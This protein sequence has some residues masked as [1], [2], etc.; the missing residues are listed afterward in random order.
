MTGGSLPAMTWQ[1]LMDYA[2]QNIDLKPIPGIDN[3]FVE[4]DV[5]AKAKAVAAKAAA[6]AAP[7][8]PATS[9]RRALG[10]DHAAAEGHVRDLPDRP[11]DADGR[12]RPETL[13]AL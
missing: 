4:P 1:R 10:R 2:H 6:G 7:G 9:A 3:P 13:S 5:A 8:K 11:A 12:G